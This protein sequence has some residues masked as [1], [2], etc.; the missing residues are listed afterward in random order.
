VAGPF[1]TH[2]ELGDLHCAGRNP[3]RH[4]RS[5][6]LDGCLLASSAIG[7]P[8]GAVIGSSAVCALEAVGSGE[9]HCG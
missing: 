5:L 3:D 8:S 9:S 4:P 7:Y 6:S 2:P 1:V